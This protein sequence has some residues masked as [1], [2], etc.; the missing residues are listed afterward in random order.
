MTELSFFFSVEGVK[1]RIEQPI[2]YRLM[3][4]AVKMAAVAA[5]FNFQLEGFFAIFDLCNS[6]TSYQV[7]SQSGEVQNR[8]SRWQLWVAPWISDWNDFSYF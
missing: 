8:F 7:L 4:C 5:I 2:I 3:Y 6:D 1:Y